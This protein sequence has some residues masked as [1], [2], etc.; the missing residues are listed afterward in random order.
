MTPVL[1]T[2]HLSRLS[3]E[4][5]GA[6]T[7]SRVGSSR[8]EYILRSCRGIGKCWDASVASLSALAGKL[9]TFVCSGMY[10]EADTDFGILKN[11]RY[12]EGVVVEMAVSFLAIARYL[13]LPDCD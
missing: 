11:F 3:C 5:S 4:V 10:F 13:M 7:H 12:S 8:A 9:S 2:D 1:I 6:L